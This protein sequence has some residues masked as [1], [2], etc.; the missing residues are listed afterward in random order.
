MFP[1]EFIFFIAL[2]YLL[3]E[4]FLF[5][6]HHNCN[7]PQFFL[8]F[9]SQTS[10]L[11]CR[12][13]FLYL[14]SG[15]G[16]LPKSVNKEWHNKL[17]KDQASLPISKLGEA[18]KIYLKNFIVKIFYLPKCFLIFSNLYYKEFIF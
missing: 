13:L 11:F 6:L 9:H 5:V 14:L 3:I 8:P 2:I 18:Y 16:R 17:K 10:P 1:C 12:L 7:S 4:H 15:R